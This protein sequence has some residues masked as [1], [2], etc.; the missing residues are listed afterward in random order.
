MRVGHYVNQFFAGIGG[1]EHAN[2][3]PAVRDGPVGPGRM[4]ESLL[5]PE[6]SVVSTLFCGDNF[7]G[8][9]RDET[10]AALRDW[11][12]RICPDAVIAGPAF[13]AGRYGHAC[14]QVC[15]VAAETGIPAV[16][17]MHPENPGVL[18]YRP[19]YIIPTCGSAVDMKPALIAMQR[20]AQ[21]LISGEP[22]GP[23]EH[24][25]YLPRGIRRPGMRDQIGAERAVAMLV[26][27]I[28][29]TPFRTELP[30]D[31]YESVPPAPGIRDLSQATIAIVTTGAIV[32]RGNPDHLKRCSETRWARYALGNRAVLRPEEFECVHGGFYNQMATDN[33]NVVLPLDVLR[34]LERERAFARLVD[35]YC[36]T[37]GNDQRLSDCRRNGAEIGETLRSAQVDGVLLVAT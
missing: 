33:P 4:L 15:R 29:G 13:S 24:E 6:G 31:A 5:R 22:L 35:F 9:H 1:E 30:V 32:P 18:V 21:Q 20:L 23:A 8:E 10:A 14:A 12:L 11:L 16:T 34:D 3:P 37:T 17:G 36:T 27:K 25:G 26:A 19:A 7:A 2:V 28:K